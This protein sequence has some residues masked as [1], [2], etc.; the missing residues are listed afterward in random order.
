MKLLAVGGSDKVAESVASLNQ[1]WWTVWRSGYGPPEHSMTRY[2]PYYFQ[3]W[4]VAAPKTLGR[5]AKV[6]LFTGVNG[7]NRSVGPATEWPVGEEMEVDPEEVIPPH[8]SEA[9]AEQLSQEYIEKFVRRRYRP[10][11]TSSIVREGF[12]LIYV[13]YYVYA[14]E[15]QP[16]KKAILIEGLTGAVGQVRDVPPVL[17]SIVDRET[18]TVGEER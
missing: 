18:V 5:V 7:M 4:K 1:K 14:K 10:I 3:S 11:R 6:I 9:E 8:T 17:R 2:Y 13:P 12:E 15:G 16:L